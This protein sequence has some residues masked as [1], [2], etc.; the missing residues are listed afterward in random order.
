MARIDEGSL[1]S[2][3][4][5]KL[6]RVLSGAGV[7]AVVLALSMLALHPPHGKPADAPANEFSAMRALDTLHRVLPDDTPHPL[8]S[9]ANDAVRIR[10]LA[11]LT[12]FGYQPVVHTSFECSDAGTCATVNNILARLDGTE[13][14]N[15]VIL[16]A[17]YDSVPASPGDSDDGVGVSSVLEIARAMK[18][19]PP[20]RHSI[21]FLIDDGEEAGLLGARA[22]VDSDPWAKQVRAAVNLDNRGTSGPSLMFE[23]GRANEWAL[24]LY[25][26]QPGRH[27]TSSV[28]YSIY[29]LLPNDTDFTAFKSAGYQGMNFAFVGGVALY[30]TP[31]DNSANVSIASLQDQGSTGL[32]SIVA[33]ANA[34][35]PSRADAGA[36]YFDFFGRKVMRWPAHW[37]LGLAILAAL[38][39]AAQVAWLM[40]KGRLTLRS[41]LWG[42]IGWIAILIATGLA[43]LVVRVIF[44]IA[45]ATPVQWVAHPLP[46]EISFA[47]LGVAIAIGFGSLIARAAGFWGLWAGAWTWGALLSI[48]SG[49]EAQGFS[50]IVLVPTIAAVVASWPGTLDPSERGWTRDVALLL[51]LATS[52][53]VQMPLIL[54]LY[55]AMGN[56]ALVAIALA[57]VLLVTPLFPLCADLEQVPG[58][59]GFVLR[60]ST[61]LAVGLAAFAA[62]VVPAYSAKSPERVNFEYALDADSGTARWI[63]YPDSGRLQAP[64]QIA[65]AFQR[66]VHGA[67]P[68][69]ARESFMADAPHL[70]LAAPT[71]TIL[72]SSLDGDRRHYTALLRSE[73][74]APDAAILFPPGAKVESVHVEGQPVQPETP[75]WTQALN[76]WTGYS[77]PSMPAAGIN[78]IFTLP[79]GKVV[80]VTAID[81]SYGLPPVGAFL[82]NARPLTATPS[83][84]GDVTVVSRRV[85][86]FP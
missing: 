64:I 10:I 58:V 68:W 72:D 18:A 22:F 2:I 48:L 61:L 82:S 31:L 53:I 38:L 49:A 28:F 24:R 66:T 75:R 84:N 3:A 44:S 17:H 80:E 12:K 45:G 63:V 79:A 21:I 86:L 1:S 20:P 15:A 32:A 70:D 60:W 7:L 56:H 11:E 50:Y 52:A 9:A 46:A 62:V 71:F 69:D 41:L 13:P 65:G 85:Q 55:E 16:S 5:P 73:R 35:V 67:F 14:G 25:A 57:V 47:L 76:G 27:L 74:G 39:L 8:A 29:K 30:H 78:V 42:I 59:G 37:T 81:R 40:H 19:M 23:T 26:R 6:R 54:L 33:L 77:C 34:D 4:Q 36:V 43:G 51:P 83:Q